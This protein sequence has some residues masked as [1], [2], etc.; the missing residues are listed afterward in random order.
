[1]RSYPQALRRIVKSQTIEIIIPETFTNTK[2]QF[3]DEPNLRYTFF[4]GFICYEVLQMPF[5]ILTGTP[6]VTLEQLRVIFPT[7]QAYGGENFTWQTFA[8]AYIDLGTA[9]TI[10][11]NSPRVFSGQLV[12]WPKSYIELASLAPFA[13]P[14]VERSF[15]IEIFYKDM[16][17]KD[18][19]E[20]KTSFS[21]RR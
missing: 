7:F 16:T 8:P 17:R 21:K 14:N 18:I 10:Q 3:P 4:M 19:D 1:M 2:F 9:A 15:L 20:A 6:V 12:N 5:S 11:Q 13:A